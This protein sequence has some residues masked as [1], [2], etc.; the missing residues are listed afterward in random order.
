MPPPA[1][2]DSRSTNV[3]FQRQ[4][5]SMTKQKN[6]YSFP[7]F[8]RLTNWSNIQFCV[9]GSLRKPGVAVSPVVQVTFT[10]SFHGVG[11]IRA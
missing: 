11:C 1:M 3:S 7:V 5:S 6:K 4:N 9:L 10:T 2:L 8:L